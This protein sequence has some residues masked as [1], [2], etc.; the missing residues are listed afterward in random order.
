VRPFAALAAL[1]FAGGALCTFWLPGILPS[2]LLPDVPFLAVVYAGL[3]VAG[4]AGLAAAAAAALAREVSSSAPP[5]S[6]FCST[7]AL[8]VIL[9]ETGARLFLR[10][11]PVVL[12][13]AALLLLA[14]SLGVCLLLSLRGSL[15]LSPLW[16]AGEAVRIA[17]TAL[18]AAPLFSFLDRLLRGGGRP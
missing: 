18:A 2:M 7:L 3:H 8:Y 6:L 17:W 16:G 13:V 5:W 1:S 9:R 4:P 15:H 10:M 11:E 12:L 14:E